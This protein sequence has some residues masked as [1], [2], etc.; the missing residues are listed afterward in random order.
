MGAD[1]P[2]EAPSGNAGAPAAL[3]NSARARSEKRPEVIGGGAQR[4]C[5][6]TATPDRLGSIA[7]TPATRAGHG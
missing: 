3:T 5:R 1:S 4:P 6:K 2:P 7:P